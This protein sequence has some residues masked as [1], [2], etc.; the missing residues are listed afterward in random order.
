MKTLAVLTTIFRTYSFDTQMFFSLT[1]SLFHF[2]NVTSY[3][4]KTEQDPSLSPWV[5][6]LIFGC[7]WSRV[8]GIHLEPTSGTI[9]SQHQG[10]H[11]LIWVVHGPGKIWG[12]TSFTWSCPRPRCDEKIHCFPL[13]ITM[14]LNKF[15][16]VLPQTK[17]PPLHHS[18]I[19]G[20]Q[21]RRIQAK[22]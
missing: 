19:C 12:L 20:D 2:T 8:Q 10:S 21:G 14:R 5:H 16:L 4:P 11:H 1:V 13:L 22:P 7:P 15:Y 6:H 3:L 9:S 18:S 17:V